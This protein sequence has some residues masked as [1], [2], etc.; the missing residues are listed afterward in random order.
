MAR[1]T[2]FLLDFKSKL[3]NRDFLLTCVN[4]YGNIIDYAPEEL[5][6]DREIKIEAMQNRVQE[7]ISSKNEEILAQIKRKR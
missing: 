5:K 4:I 2:P 3:E 1:E 6:N 7:D